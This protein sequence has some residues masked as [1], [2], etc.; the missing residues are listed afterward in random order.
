MPAHEFMEF[1]VP[2]EHDGSEPACVLP[3]HDRNS[4]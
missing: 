3:M 2:V 1:V 4:W